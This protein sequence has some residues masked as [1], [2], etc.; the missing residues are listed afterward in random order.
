MFF[1]S[2]VLT[3]EPVNDNFRLW[4]TAEE[5]PKF[6]I[7]FLQSSIKF[8]NEPPQGIKAGVKRTYAGISQVVLLKEPPP[9]PTPP[10]CPRIPTSLVQRLVYCRQKSSLK[11][12]YSVPHSSCVSIILTIYCFQKFGFLTNFRLSIHLKSHL[13]FFAS[14]STWCH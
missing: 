8:T 1:F 13:F 3:T 6:P 14:G 5:H 11:C 10:P 2:Q 4:I 12:Y 9:P 7:N